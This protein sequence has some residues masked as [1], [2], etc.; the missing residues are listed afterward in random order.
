MEETVQAAAEEAARREREAADRRV[1]AA[2]KEVLLQSQTCAPASLH[3]L[4]QNKMMFHA[5]FWQHTSGISSYVV[6]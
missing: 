3:E 4:L 5:L 1:I 2:E 6:G